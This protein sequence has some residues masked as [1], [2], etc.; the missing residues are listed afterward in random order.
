M[1]RFFIFALA[2]RAAAFLGPVPKFHI[3]SLLSSSLS[4]YTLEGKT[5]QKPF[6]PLNNM[7]LLKKADIVDQTGGG[8]FLTG[9]VSEIICGVGNSFL[10]AS[11]KNQT[12]FLL[13]HVF[14]LI[15]IG[16]N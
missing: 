6:T 14:F 8:I 13:F 4:E 3:Q 2:Y 10:V 5:I 9:K 15:Y 11:D 7:L 12:L 1:L 16:Q